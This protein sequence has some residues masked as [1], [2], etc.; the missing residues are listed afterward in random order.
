MIDNIIHYLTFK[1]NNYNFKQLFIKKIIDN[2]FY[3]KKKVYNESITPLS[4]ININ[5][6]GDSTFSHK[7][8]NEN[9]FIIFLDIDGVLN[10]GSNLTTFYDDNVFPRLEKDFIQLINLLHSI[11]TKKIYFI[12]NSTWCDSYISLSDFINYFNEH[13]FYFNIMDKISNGN[14]KNDSI[15]E[16]IEEYNIKNFLIIDDESNLYSSSCLK[17]KLISPKNGIN[18]DNIENIKNFIIN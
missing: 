13:N 11:H 7:D 4:S 2:G 3:K 9:D 1:F 15:L 17:E 8:I 6:T 14:N 16:K 18:I 10:G 12:L 5:K